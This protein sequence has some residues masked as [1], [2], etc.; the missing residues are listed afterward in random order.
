MQIE[1]NNTIYY[2]A[3][4]NSGFVVYDKYTGETKFV[5]DEEQLLKSFPD[6]NKDYFTNQQ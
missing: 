2:K 3:R 6:I 5:S 4:D 1:L